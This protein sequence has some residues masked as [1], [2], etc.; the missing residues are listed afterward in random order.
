MLFLPPGVGVPKRLHGAFVS[1]SEVHRVVKRIRAQS[2]DREYI[3]DF[4]EQNESEMER[5]RRRQRQ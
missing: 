2:E 5:N 4:S 3:A 1:D